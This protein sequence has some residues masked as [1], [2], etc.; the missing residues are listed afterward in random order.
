LLEGPADETVVRAVKQ[1]G[2][3]GLNLAVLDPFN[4]DL[5]QFSVIRTLATLKHVDIIA[6]FSLMDL[7]RNLIT[8]Y[9]E[10]GGSF[11]LVAPNWRNHVRAERLNKREAPQMFENY[12]IK[13]VEQ[14]G[15]KASLHRP[16][17][18]NSRRA[19]LYRL[20]LFSR[21]PTAH[22]IWN[23]ATTDPT[24]SGFNF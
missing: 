2:Q 10:G 1:I 4:L 11:D 24:Q 22:K 17:F 21:H 19:E 20:I 18:K 6:H 16:V 12:W 23:S 3:S 8:Q 14:T 5:L 15:L 13:L 9:R 7:R